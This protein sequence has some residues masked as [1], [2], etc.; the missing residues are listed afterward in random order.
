MV[1]AIIAICYL[2]AQHVLSV[3]DLASTK[4]GIQHSVDRALRLSVG[5]WGEGWKDS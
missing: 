5:V 2:L 1:E 4:E 3:T